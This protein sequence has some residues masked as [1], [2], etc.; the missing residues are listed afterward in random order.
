VDRR[1]FRAGF[2]ESYLLI[3]QSLAPKTY[4]FLTSLFDLFIGAKMEPKL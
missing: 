4:Q 2:A 3:L 1:L